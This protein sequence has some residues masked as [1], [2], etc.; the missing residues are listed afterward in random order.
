MLW[1]FNATTSWWFSISFNFGFFY[2]S[3]RENKGEIQRGCFNTVMAMMITGSEE[4]GCN[5]IPETLGSGNICICDTELCNSSPTKLIGTKH[6]L[7]AA[8][9]MLFIIV[10]NH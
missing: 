7:L 3:E 8:A 2:F 5:P 9:I 4:V 10:F 1:F 6:L